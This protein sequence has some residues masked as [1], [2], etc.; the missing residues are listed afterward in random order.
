MDD[1]YILLYFCPKLRQI[2]TIFQNCFTVR[3]HILIVTHYVAAR[4][5]ASVHFRPCI[6][7]T[8]TLVEVS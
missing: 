2:L 1:F 5:E 8:D 4:D 7:R 6:T 3:L